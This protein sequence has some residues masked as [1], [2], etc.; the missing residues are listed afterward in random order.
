MDPL[1]LEEFRALRATIRARG[2]LRLALATSGFSAWALVLVAVLAW[3]P[4]PIA[5]TIPLVLLVSGFEVNRMLHLGIERIGRYLQVFYEDHADADAGTPAWERTV[6]KLAPSVPGAGGHAL[7]L[8]TFL[9]ATLINFLSVVLPGPLPLELGVMA[10]PHLVF[11]AWMI[12]CDRG[13]RRQRAQELEAFAK[14]RS[15]VDSR[16]STGG[17]S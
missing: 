15:T 8:P 11:I 12:W 13:M 14:I 7:L 16:H 5:G 6:M 2:S 9:I 1:S 3:L 10:V 17:R 4:N